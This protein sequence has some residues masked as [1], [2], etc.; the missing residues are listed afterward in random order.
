[1]RYPAILC[2]V[3]LLSLGCGTQEP[4]LQEKSNSA[5]KR[6]DEANGVEA[7]NTQPSTI[8]NTVPGSTLANANGENPLTTVRN[9]KLD[10]IR[11]AGPD[12]NAPELDVE[13]IL[14]QST[15][16]APE[17]SQF[18]VALTD[19]LVERRTFLSHPI[20]LKAEKVTDGENK[21]LH[22]F[23]RDGKMFEAQGDRVPLLSTASAAAIL[24]AVGIEAPE[25]RAAAKK[26]N[27]P[28][29]K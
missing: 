25:S 11:K 7:G 4:P 24:K 12:A 27:A 29:Q 28:N 19:I 10:A 5:A 3:I 1:M 8:P 18:S 17:N 14:K 15:R 16:P 13:A 20:L 2:F 9:K 21:T 23:T 26:P 6:L 22:V